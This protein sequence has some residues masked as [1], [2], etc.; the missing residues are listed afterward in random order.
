MR[1]RSLLDHDSLRRD[2]VLKPTPGLIMQPYIITVV[3]TILAVFFGTLHAA[4]L[5]PPRPSDLVIRT[6][7]LG[8]DPVA[9]AF[10]GSRDL[11]VWSQLSEIDG[12]FVSA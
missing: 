12:R 10:D 4:A 9:V 6:G 3:T 8:A 7:W 1:W 2:P 11:V 5:G